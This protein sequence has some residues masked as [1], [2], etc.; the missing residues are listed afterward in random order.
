[1]LGC[2]PSRAACILPFDHYGKQGRQCTHH[3]STRFDLCSEQCQ[4]S[5]IGWRSCT[6]CR[7]TFSILLHRGAAKGP[8]G[9]VLAAVEKWISARV[10]HLEASLAAQITRRVWQEFLSGWLPLAYRAAHC[11]EP[12]ASSAQLGQQAG[13]F[14][15]AEIVTGAGGGSDSGEGAYSA[16]IIACMALPKDH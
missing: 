14:A 8:A 11:N 9:S 7:P 2:R 4:A 5:C 13:S 12:Q 10:E 1:M 15:G 16:G 3:D 6:Q